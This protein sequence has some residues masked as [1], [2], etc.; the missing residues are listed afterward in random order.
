[1]RRL[2]VIPGIGGPTPQLVLRSAGDLAALQWIHHAED[3]YDTDRDVPAMTTGRDLPLMRAAGEVIPVTSD[4]ELFDAA[5][6]MHKRSPLD[7]V[8]TFSESAVAVAARIADALGLRHNPPATAALLTNKHR[9]RA[10]LDAAGIPVPAYAPIRTGADLAGAAER[11]G[12][13]SVLKPVQGGGSMLTTLVESAEQLDAAATAGLATL[14]TAAS[15]RGKARLLRGAEPPYLLLE[16]LLPGAAWRADPRYGDYVSVESAAYDGQLQHLSVSDKAPLS[17][18]FRE[19]A[20]FAPS[21]LPADRLAQLYDM[22]AAALRALGVVHGITHTE[23]KLTADGPRIIEVNG[24]LGGG[25]WRLLEL[26]A[27]YDVIAEAAHAAL[28]LRAMAPVRFSRHAGF[29]TPMLD[30]A[31]SGQRIAVT[32]D[33]GYPGRGGI[34]EFLDARVS[35][36]DAALGGGVAALAVVAGDHAEDVQ[37]HAS[38]LRD[39]IHI[40]PA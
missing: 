3:L 12:F 24:R 36:F 20:S 29:L 1:M 34:H 18:G 28:G 9:Q 38:A 2:L 10:A 16:A 26:A 6:A 27:G 8:L 15:L 35:T 21:T 30:A 37:D 7:G 13:P 39:A 25:V 4:D 32:I 33:P 23:L 22:T 14:A 17:G 40:V 31:L 11:V 19:N 5:V